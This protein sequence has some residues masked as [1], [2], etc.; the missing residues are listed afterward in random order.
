MTGGRFQAP[1]AIQ[2][3]AGKLPGWLELILAAFALNML[4]VLP[5]HVEG[6]APGVPKLAP[7][8]LFLVGVCALLPAAWWAGAVRLLASLA[9]VFSMA[10]AGGAAAVN[11][12]LGRPLN[13]YYDIGLVRNGFHLLEGNLGLG[14]AVGGAV[15]AALGVIAAVA[16]VRLLLGRREPGRQTRRTAVMMA[17]AGGL[18][19][20]AVA[21]GLRFP[22]WVDAPVVDSV[23]F[24]AGQVFRTHRDRQAFEQTLE[25]GGMPARALP[26]LEDRHVYLVYIESWGVSAV[27]DPRFSTLVLPR[28]AAMSENL[29][30]EGIHM[31]SGRVD[32]PIRGGQ[33]WLAHATVLSGLEIGNQLWYRMMLD[34]A[35]ATLID[36]FQATGH[37]TMAVMPALTMPWPEGR[38]LG[39][40]SIFKAGD[41]R[42]EGPP[43]NWVT[44]PDQYTLDHFSRSLKTS[45][46]GPLFAQIALISS[47]APWTPVLPL[48]DDWDRIG[49]GRIFEPWR[50][51]GIS[52]EELWRDMEQVRNHYALAVDYSMHVALDWVRQH[53]EQDA[54]VLLIGDHQPAPLVTGTD[55]PPTV[56]VH[57]LSRD[58]ELIQ[59]FL[60]RDFH[61]GLIPPPVD[62]VPPMHEIRHWLHTDF[63]N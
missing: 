1:D 5:L 17:L 28:L 41:M 33:S 14:G 25:A 20:V 55:A 16:L 21:A 53:V 63:A 45:V 40:D 29:A 12:A 11:Q 57:M 22:G 19:V 8:S 47:H 26:G 24:Q 51:A 6:F 56:P 13:L 18:L 34:H 23:S 35:P 4:L 54:L 62:N 43:L 15:A 37:E 2:S 31:A 42:Y 39:F 3:G 60:Q 30:G 10:A 59:P 50:D 48:I 58:P 27:D 44:M 32:A 9:C 61:P 46:T 7:E 36:D 52:P 49:D 38:K